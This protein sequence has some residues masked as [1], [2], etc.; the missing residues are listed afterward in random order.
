MSKFKQ[1]EKKLE[2][3]GKSEKSAKAIAGSIMWKKYGK[4]GGKALIKKGKRK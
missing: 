2:K 1:L 4:A 3:S